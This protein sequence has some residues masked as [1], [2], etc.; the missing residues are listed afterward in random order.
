MSYLRSA[1]VKTQQ[2]KQT[3]Y[4]YPQNCCL[5]Q[6][7]LWIQLFFPRFHLQYP[8]WLYSSGGVLQEELAML[9][10]GSFCLLAQ[11]RS[12]QIWQFATAFLRQL[13]LCIFFKYWFK[14][15]ASAS[16]VG[17]VKSLFFFFAGFVP[18]QLFLPHFIVY[19][20]SA[21]FVMHVYCP[22]PS[23]S[24]LLFSPVFTRHILLSTPHTPLASH[25]PLCTTIHPPLCAFLLTRQPLTDETAVS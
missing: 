4:K 16:Q 1:F 20:S 8:R 3:F 18:L 9:K 17:S 13:G 25:L 12:L 22:F 14:G 5:S 15:N 19:M 21:L 6:T 23:S 24:R 11:M 10:R 2:K 7:G